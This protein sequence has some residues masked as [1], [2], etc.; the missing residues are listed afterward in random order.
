MRRAPLLGL[1]VLLASLA[2]AAPAQAGSCAYGGYQPVLDGRGQ[3]TA[4]LTEGC[5]WAPFAGAQ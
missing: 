4:T 1:L 3:F 2:A 5:Y